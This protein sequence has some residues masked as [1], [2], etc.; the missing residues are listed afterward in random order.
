MSFR[1]AVVGDVMLDAYFFCRVVG[2][3]PED[4]LAP[5][6]C[7]KAKTYRPGGA[8]NVACCLARWGVPVGLFGVCGNDFPCETLSQLLRKEEL[9]RVYLPSIQDRVTTCKTRLVTPKSRQVVRFDEESEIDLSEHDVRH[10]V[11][12]VFDYQPDWLVFSDYNKGVVSPAL[13]SYFKSA[14]LDLPA[15]VDPKT[16]HF[17]MYGPVLAITPNEKEF[18]AFKDEARDPV[19]P[20]CQAG[21]LIITRAEKG[22]RV[23]TGGLQHEFE[24]PVRK[25]EIGDP[26]GCGDA[27]LAALVYSLS[28]GNSFEKACLTASAAGAL[29]FDMLGVACPTLEQIEVELAHPEYKEVRRG[30]PR[31]DP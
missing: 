4:E 20:S 5:K 7:L 2:F 12:A 27:F 8:A 6:L 26:A 16:P 25:R 19:N 10:L 18:Q 11:Q 28:S 14:L 13:L 15:V 1:V 23:C 30:Y 29:A 22:S 9:E 21:H 24:V 17:E 3:S 31:S